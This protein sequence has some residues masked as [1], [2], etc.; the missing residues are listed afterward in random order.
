MGLI[1]DHVARTH[2]AHLVPPAVHESAYAQVDMARGKQFGQ[3]ASPA[4]NEPRL[5]LQRLRKSRGGVGI[6]SAQAVHGSIHP[7]HGGNVAEA[8]SA[9]LADPPAVAERNVGE[10]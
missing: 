2:A 10:G 8:H 3:V 1:L 9:A 6:V 7:G 4:F 5:H